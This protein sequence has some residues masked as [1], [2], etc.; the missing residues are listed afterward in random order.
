MSFPHPLDAGFTITHTGIFINNAFRPSSTGATFDTYDPATGRLL[1][2]IADAS[3]SDVED[4]VAAA[5][6]AFTSGPWPLLDGPSR[7]ALLLRLAALLERDAER[8]AT[9]EALDSGKPLRMARLADVGSA[10]RVLRHFASLA[11]ATGGRGRVLPAP[12]SALQPP[13]LALTL[14]SPIGVVAGILPFNFPLCGAVA[15]LAPALAA[16]CTLV[17]KPSQQCPLSPLHLAALCA[18]AGVPPGV[19][20]VLPGGRA[21][22]AALVAHGGVAKISFTGSNAVGRGIASVAAARCARTTLELGGKNALIVCPDYADVEAAA[23]V[24]CGANYFNAGQ[25]CEWAGGAQQCFLFPRAISLPPHH[26]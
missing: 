5:A 26:L 15:K 18:E 1:A 4:A 25:I 14:S 2:S 9:L 16:G 7:G 12:S 21:T 20:N 8:V 11:D 13:S 10:L 6:T 17:L 22:G 23:K 19:V 3:P 24:A